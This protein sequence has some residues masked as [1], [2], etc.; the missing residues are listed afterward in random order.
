MFA[1]RWLRNNRWE[2]YCWFFALANLASTVRDVAIGAWNMSVLNA[3]VAVYLS[4]FGFR[5]FRKRTGR[6]GVGGSAV[7]GSKDSA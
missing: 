1:L 2:V 3:A 6:G 7:A 5:D 4:V